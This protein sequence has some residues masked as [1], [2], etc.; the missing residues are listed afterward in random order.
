MIELII[1]IAVLLIGAMVAIPMITSADSFQLSSVTNMIASDMEYAK[2]MAIT[3]GGLYSVVFDKTNESY[4]IV[5]QGGSVISHPVKIGFSY[6]VSLTADSRTDKV[7]IEDVDFGSTSTV[8]FDS[9]GSP[10]DG[11]DNPLSAG[12]IT[13]KAGDDEMTISVEP[14]TG[15]ISFQ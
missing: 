12:D 7:E 4:Q 6:S 1:V 9:F 5:D 3:R 2:Q 8:K 15:H 11:S 14:V 10:Y 13:L